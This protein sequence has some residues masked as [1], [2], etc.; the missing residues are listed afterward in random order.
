MIKA[1]ALQSGRPVT[2]PAALKESEHTDFYCV[3]DQFDFDNIGVSH[4]H[5]QVRYLSCAD[6]SATRKAIADLSAIRF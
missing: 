6:V 3:Q 2:I 4:Q 1:K 5:H